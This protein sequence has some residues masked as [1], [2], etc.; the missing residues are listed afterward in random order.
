[1]VLHINGEARELPLEAASVRELLEH[2]DLGSKLILVELNREAVDR[3]SFDEVVVRD[4]D[5]IELVQFVGGG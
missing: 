5:A 3:S 2:L 4:G 1:M